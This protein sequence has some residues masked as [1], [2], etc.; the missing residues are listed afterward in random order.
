[1]SYVGSCDKVTQA[2]ALALQLRGSSVTNKTR[3]QQL[4]DT[5]TASICNDQVASGG[6]RNHGQVEI[7]SLNRST[8]HTVKPFQLGLPV[9]FL[10]HMMEPCPTEEDSEEN[11]AAK[12]TA[13]SG[14][15]ICVGLQDGK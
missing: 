10:D 14:N 11:A 1:M 9:L 12:N 15:T 7:F 3:D 2:L 4:V 8:P 6:D 13:S 5:L